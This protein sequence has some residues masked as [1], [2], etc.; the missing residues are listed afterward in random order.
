MIPTGIERGLVIPIP[1]AL[2]TASKFMRE[3]KV[4]DT[5]L[6]PTPGFNDH[7]GHLDFF[8]T[9][10]ND[11]EVVALLDPARPDLGT[12]MHAQLIDY[13]GAHLDLTVKLIGDPIVDSPPRF[14]IA[15]STA[16]GSRTPDE[17]RALMDVKRRFMTPREEQIGGW[18]TPA[19]A[20]HYSESREMIGWD[21]SQTPG[22][23]I[24]R[25]LLSSDFYH[26]VISQINLAKVRL[27]KLRIS[28]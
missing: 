11:P 5:V 1:E 23:P 17:I 13:E 2:D 16:G 25:E 10:L 22:D 8:E 24:D 9:V 7:Q 4:P 15:I 18:T 27:R 21:F 3:L 19:S 12:W 6:P 28:V 14:R 26:S 20:E